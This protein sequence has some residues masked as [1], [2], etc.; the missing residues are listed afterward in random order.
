MSIIDLPSLKVRLLKDNEGKS[1]QFHPN[2][3]F[4]HLRLSPLAFILVTQS[5]STE[6]ANLDANYYPSKIGLVSDDRKIFWNL[7]FYRSEKI[8]LAPTLASLGLTEDQKMYQKMAQDFATN[9]M[10]PHMERWDKEVSKDYKIYSLL[11]QCT[12]HLSPIS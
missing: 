9:E 1:P 12:Q 6:Y 5:T 3:E 11:W 8:T 4:T 7:P 2:F 10:R